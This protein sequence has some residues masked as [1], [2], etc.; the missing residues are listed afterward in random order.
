M[1][2]RLEQDEGRPINY[3]EFLQILIRETQKSRIHTS[4]SDF[5]KLK[6]V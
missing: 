1:K 2:S 3:D 4:L 6:G 5:Q